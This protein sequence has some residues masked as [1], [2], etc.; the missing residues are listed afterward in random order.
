MI[1]QLEALANALG[2]PLADLLLT[3]PC[4]A[5]LLETLGRGLCDRPALLPEL[6]SLVKM[7]ER[8]LATRVAPHVIGWLCVHERLPEL[9][10]LAAK[11]ETSVASLFINHAYHAIAYALWFAYT[12]RL[13]ACGWGR[14][15]RLCS[16][17]LAFKSGGA[18]SCRC[19]AWRG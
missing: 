2:R 12:V 17:R 5:Q 14:G 18:S 8:A 6:A 19:G 10:A 7:S 13:H 1:E 16:L 4:S 3:G 15:R 9:S 11:L